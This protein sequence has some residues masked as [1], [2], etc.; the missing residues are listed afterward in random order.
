MR[1][2]GGALLIE[3]RLLVLSESIKHESFE[4]D[5]EKIRSLLLEAVD[6]IFDLRRVKRIAR[7][8]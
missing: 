7:E 5:A 8:D 4:M 1:L 3:R 2:R 6:T